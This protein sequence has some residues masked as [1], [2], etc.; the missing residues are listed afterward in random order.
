MATIGCISQKAEDQRRGLDR[1]TGAG[2][3]VKQMAQRD[4]LSICYGGG[5]F[6]H[7]Q[8]ARKTGPIEKA[9]DD[10]IKGSGS[11]DG[12]QRCGQERDIVGKG[13]RKTICIKL[14]CAQSAVCNTMV[15][16]PIHGLAVRPLDAKQ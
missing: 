16:S 3:L 4:V 13:Y 1:L 9:C 15:D 7:S 2:I 14:I 6:P 10:V 5:I 11:F 8:C 12:S